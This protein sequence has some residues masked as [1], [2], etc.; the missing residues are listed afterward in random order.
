[1][2]HYNFDEKAETKIKCNEPVSPFNVY[3]TAPIRLHHVHRNGQQF[4]EGGK[5]GCESHKK[6]NCKIS[7]KVTIL[8]KHNTT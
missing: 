1:M 7:T 3:D 8:I 5:G 4:K 6:I 2:R